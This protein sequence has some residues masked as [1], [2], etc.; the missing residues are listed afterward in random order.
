[1]AAS[2]EFLCFGFVVVSDVE[3]EVTVFVAVATTFVLFGPVDPE[4][5]LKM[6]LAL[7]RLNG[8]YVSRLP[9]VH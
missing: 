1:M 8:R 2:C 7:G 6:T 5:R 3:V 9:V 4:V